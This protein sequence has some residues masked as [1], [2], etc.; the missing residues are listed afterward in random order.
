MQTG[1]IFTGKK[2]SYSEEK[3]VLKLKIRRLEQE[4]RNIRNRADTLDPKIAGKEEAKT[5]SAKFKSESQQKISNLV[6]ASEKIL[7]EAK[8]MLPPIFYLD[9][10]KVDINKITIVNKRFLEPEAPRAIII[11]EIVSVSYFN[12][13]VFASLE[14]IDSK[15]DKTVLKYLNPKKAEEVKKILDGLLVSQKLQVDPASITGIKTEELKE[16]FEKIGA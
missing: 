8:S 7:I 14:I 11:S 9:K 10:I 13:Y 5:E 3:E 4:V 16:K 12:A 6:N 2:V 15:K 1:V